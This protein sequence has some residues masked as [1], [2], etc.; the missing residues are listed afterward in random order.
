[1]GTWGFSI[2]MMGSVGMNASG[3]RGRE[4][5]VSGSLMGKRHG[6]SGKGV[7]CFPGAAVI[8]HRKGVG[9]A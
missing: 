5:E 8:K 3:G 4:A 2:L 6:G 1:M 9:A 7:S